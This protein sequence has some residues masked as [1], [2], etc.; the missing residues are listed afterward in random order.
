MKLTYAALSSVGPV[1]PH[2]EDFVKFWE[3]ED[4]R[5]MRAR[6]A[7]AL[8]ADGVGGHGAGEIA[9][10][11]AVE[12]ALRTF[13]DADPTATDNQLDQKAAHT[14]PKGTERAD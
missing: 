14:E 7:V 1:R 2:N 6:G 11:M 3:A 5:E 8:L 13:H 9:S 10:E 12:T 4:E